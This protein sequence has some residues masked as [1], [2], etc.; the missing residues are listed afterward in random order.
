MS[1]E[2]IVKQ[3]QD[4]VTVSCYIQPKASKNMVVGFF[5]NNLKIKIQSPPVDGKANQALIKFFS[6]SLKIA[7]S[8]ISIVAGEQSRTK[9]IKI[10]GDSNKLQVQLKEW[11]SGFYFS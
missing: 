6:K 7:A 1:F 3:K 10:L 5:N 11:I 2:K 8:N 9:V 4:G